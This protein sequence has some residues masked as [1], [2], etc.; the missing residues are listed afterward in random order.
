[1]IKDS[2]SY[3]DFSEVFKEFRKAPYFEDWTEQ[4]LKEEYDFL[5]TNGFIFGKY[6]DS[7]MI[8]LASYLPNKQPNHKIEFPVDKKIAYLS[9]L[10]VLEAYRKKGI[11]TELFVYALNDIIR[12]QYDYVYFRTVVNGSLS[13][14]IGIRNGFEIV[15]DENS[16]LVTQQLSFPRVKDD[17]P[18]V[19]DRKFLVKKL[20]RKN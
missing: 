7:Q 2:V 13:E 14:G 12:N 15:Y 11:G 1:M 3:E 9:D 4:L 10:A 5:T 8:G 6:I 17:V 16:K 18:E 20:E 19:E